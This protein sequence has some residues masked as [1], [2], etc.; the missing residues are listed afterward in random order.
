VHGR[1]FSTRRWLV[2][3]R[4]PEPV[5]LISAL[6]IVLGVLAFAKIA[7][8]VSEADAPRFDDQILRCLR[9]ADN[10]A[11]LIGPRWVSGAVRDL[12]SLGAAPVLVLV[13][14]VVAGFLRLAGKRRMM[15][16][17]LLAPFSGAV[18]MWALKTVFARPRPNV[19]PHLDAVSSYSFPSGH[20]ML[21]AVVYLTLGALIAGMLPRWRLRVYVLMVA[22]SATFLVGVSR[23][24]L[25]VH[26][27]TDV[28]AGWAAGLVWALL[29]LL[30]GRF[31]ALAGPGKQGTDGI[32]TR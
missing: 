2:V 11:E 15:W 7:D 14:A 13:I 19:V 4:Q 18:M 26:Y 23:V 29:W 28:L 16:L 3:L 22:A 10:P 20:S 31:L 5:V 1:R 8:E 9:V 30:V 17:V 27:P 6:V 12:S 25:G 21:S 24:M 32:P